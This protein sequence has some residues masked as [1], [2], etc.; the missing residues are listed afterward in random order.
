[1]ASDKSSSAT[2]PQ[3]IKCR[4]L[5]IRSKEDLLNYPSDCLPRLPKNGLLITGSHN[6]STQAFREN[7]ENILITSSSV[8]IKD[9]LAEFNYLWNKGLQESYVSPF[10][11]KLN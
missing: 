3:C 6:F 9:Y 5:R 2:V 7:F 10:P 8:H 11:Q 4:P 1:M